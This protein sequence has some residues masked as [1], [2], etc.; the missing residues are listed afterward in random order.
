MT[1]Y[2]RQQGEKRFFAII[3]PWNDVIASLSLSDPIKEAICRF[4]CDILLRFPGVGRYATLPLTVSR[5]S[6]Q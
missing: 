3:S 6:L 1:G 2:K 5:V 4:C